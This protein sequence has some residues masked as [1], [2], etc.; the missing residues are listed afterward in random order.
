MAEYISDNP[1]FIVN[2][3]L[4]SGITGALDEAL[5][6]NEADDDSSDDCETGSDV[7]SISDESDT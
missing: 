6:D 1:Q 7:N 3:F 2:G 4:R 5:Q